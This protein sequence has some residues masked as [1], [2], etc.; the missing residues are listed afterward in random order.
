MSILARRQLRLSAKAVIA[1]LTGVTV[2]S[3]GDWNIVPSKLPN[4]RVRVPSERKSS[5]TRSM[6]TFTTTASLQILATL[7]AGTADDAQ[8][9][10]DALGQLIE[11]AFFSAQPLV[12]MCQQFTSVNTEVEVT[13]EGERHI[14]RMLMTVDCEMFESFDPTEINPADYPALQQLNVHVDMLAPFDP[15]GTYANPPFPDS[16]TPAPR[17]SGPDGRDEGRLQI[18]LPQ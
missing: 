9:Q 2:E 12:R 7:Q 14:A 1:A 6:P 11:A 18:D 13:A 4:I 16:V 8:D 17:T 10:I 15:S 5:S 3:P